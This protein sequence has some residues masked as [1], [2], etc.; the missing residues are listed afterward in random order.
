MSD[1]VRCRQCDK[2]VTDEA[3]SEFETICYA[4]YNL[5]SIQYAQDQ[6]EG[7][8]AGFLASYVCWQCRSKR[9]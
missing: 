9:G 2:V 6:T 1:E 3:V 5:M 7:Q 4:G 8:R